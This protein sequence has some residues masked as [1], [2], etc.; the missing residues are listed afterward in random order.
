MTTTA[1]PALLTFSE[2][3]AEDLDNKLLVLPAFPDAVTRIQFELQSE[4]KS[5]EE[6]ARLLSAEP[7]LAARVLQIA[8][9]FVIRRAGSEVRDL[10]QAITRMGFGMVR[11]VATSF[12]LK[13]VAGDANYSDISKRELELALSDSVR[14]ASVCYVFAKR[15]TN[16]NPDEAML[17][18]LLHTI[19][20]LYLI[21][22]VSDDDQLSESDLQA[23]TAEWHASVGRVL[24][25]SWKLPEALS[26]AIDQQDAGGEARTG[27]VSLTDIL[28]AAR[29]VIREADLDSATESLDSI[30]LDRLGV[31]RDSETGAFD[32]SSCMEEIDEIQ[33]ALGG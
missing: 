17:T 32:L 4:D 10:R 7:A 30:V 18:G 31:P 8:N 23:T 19:G 20:R 22:R 33:A 11:S 26:E 14:A 12:G 5:V 21:K 16:L 3:L 2:K 28:I 29:T 24:A 1:S 6:I 13:Q 15:Y 27:P 25:E 9:A